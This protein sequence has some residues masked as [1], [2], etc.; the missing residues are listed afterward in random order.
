MADPDGWPALTAPVAAAAGRAARWAS[1]G[2]VLF[3]IG[4]LAFH[5]AAL[6]PGGGLG[7]QLLAGLVVAVWAGL[8]AAAGAALAITSTLRRAL[9]EV[10]RRLHTLVHPVMTRVIEATRLGRTGVSLERFEQVLDDEIAALASAPAPGRR[11]LPRLVARF[12]GRHALRLVQWLLV[13]EF[14]DRL[15][16]QGQS[17]VTP[18][19]VEA[20]AREKLV[21]LLADRLR[22]QINAVH[23]TAWA[24]SAVM[25]GGPIVYLLSRR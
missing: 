16:R 3:A 14:L 11:S 4:G 24:V 18:A 6:G 8:G 22:A 13:R 25:V 17:Q 12:V 5:R 21:G 19:A 23:W 7:A 20:F 9:P 10:E 2:A 1:L 15:R